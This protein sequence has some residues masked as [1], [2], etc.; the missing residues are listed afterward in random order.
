MAVPEFVTMLLPAFHVRVGHL[1]HE[2]RK[3]TV[4]LRPNDKMPM[5]G[6]QTLSTQPHP[7][8]PQRFLDD[9]LECQEF[10]LFGEKHSPAHASAEHV[11]NHPT[12]IVPPCSRHA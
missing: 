8:S 9:P 11:E 1:L 2:R 3:I 6:H 12:R 7:T 5:V 10:R 4:P